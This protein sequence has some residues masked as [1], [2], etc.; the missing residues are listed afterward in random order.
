MP[1]FL[2]SL[3]CRQSMCVCVCQK[4]MFL[5]FKRHYANARI[6]I[7]AT[8]FTIEQP[9]SLIAQSSTYIFYLQEQEHLEGTCWH[10]S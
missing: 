8:E 1:D 4:E 3:S 10:N 9:S 5:A 6:I 2:K 7:D